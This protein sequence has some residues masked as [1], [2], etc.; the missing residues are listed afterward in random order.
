MNT[1]FGGR[2]RPHFVIRR[3]ITFDSGGALP[4]MAPPALTGP[5]QH[6]GCAASRDEADSAGR[7]EAG[8]E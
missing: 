5:D 1:R 2:Q 6:D 8:G 4:K 3:W 7:N